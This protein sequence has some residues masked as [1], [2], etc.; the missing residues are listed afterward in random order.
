MSVGI[1][2]V[3]LDLD[4][5][6]YSASGFDRRPDPNLKWSLRKLLFSDPGRKSKAI[7]LDPGTQ[8][9]HNRSWASMDLN[10]SLL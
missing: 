8:R 7:D 6:I 5:D 10:F 4:P 3:W 9:L 2:V 1:F